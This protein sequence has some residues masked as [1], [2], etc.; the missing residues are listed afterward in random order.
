MAFSTWPKG[1][2]RATVSIKFLQVYYYLSLNELIYHLTGLLSQ[3]YE[4]LLP[5]CSGNSTS[6]RQTKAARIGEME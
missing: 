2:C 6:R 3:K 1:M 5:D 4:L